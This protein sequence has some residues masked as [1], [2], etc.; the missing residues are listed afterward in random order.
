M[1][2]SHAR[3]DDFVLSGHKVGHQWRRQQLLTSSAVQGEPLPCPGDPW[4]GPVASSRQPGEFGHPHG[5]R[6]TETKLY[7][8]AG[9]DRNLLHS[10]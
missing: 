2:P 6:V 10:V 9:C 1:D 4:L 7:R 3:D 8:K 5:R